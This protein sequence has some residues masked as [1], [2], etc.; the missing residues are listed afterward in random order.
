MIGK[1]AMTFKYGK[2]RNVSKTLVSKFTKKK[3]NEMENM[4]RGDQTI[5]KMFAL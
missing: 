3:C 1:P 4:I 2:C 5:V